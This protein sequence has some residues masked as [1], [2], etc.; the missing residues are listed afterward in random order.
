MGKKLTAQQKLAQ[1]KSPK[2]VRLEYDFSGLKAGSLMFVGTPQIIND[3]VKAI[4]YGETRTITAMR[5][6]LA[7]RRGCDD[8]CPVSTAFF[9]RTVAVA[10]LEDID[11]GKPISDVTPFWRLI[12]SKDKVA[13]KLPIDPEWIDLQRKLEKEGDHQ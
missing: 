4:P 6:Q 8:T 10:A 9:V 11:A 13:A 5:R 2:K 3:F 1:Q 7:R 12:S